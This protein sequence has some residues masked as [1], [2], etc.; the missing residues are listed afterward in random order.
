MFAFSVVK[1]TF[2]LL[3]VFLYFFCCF[4]LDVFDVVDHFI[5]NSIVYPV[6]AYYQLEVKAKLGCF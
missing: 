5:A 4:F 1:E 6:L 3:R 2:F